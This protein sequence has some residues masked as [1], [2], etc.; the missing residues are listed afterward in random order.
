MS[1]VLSIVHPPVAPAAYG[2]AVVHAPAPMAETFDQVSA[3]MTEH[4]GSL[5]PV[6]LP[7][8]LAYQLVNTPTGTAVYDPATSCTFRIDPADT[9]PNVCPCCGRLVVPE[10]AMFAGE[11]DTLCDGCYTW[12]RTT[13]QCLPA[14]TA[15]TEEPVHD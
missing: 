9:P 4:F 7:G 12:H 3:F 15:H 6:N 10:D 8:S 11:D 2:K 14:N 1:Y 5:G 13:P